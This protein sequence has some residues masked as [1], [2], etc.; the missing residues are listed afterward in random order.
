MQDVN[1]SKR[2]CI[3]SRWLL[4][5]D[6][7]IVVGTFGKSLESRVVG[8][9]SAVLSSRAAIVIAALSWS[10]GIDMRQRVRSLVGISLNCGSS[11]SLITCLR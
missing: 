11:A 2:I 5:D 10:S 3:T 6:V 7:R 4:G 9:L 8:L 1:E